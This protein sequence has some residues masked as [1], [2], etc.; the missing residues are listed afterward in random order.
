MEQIVLKKH[1][2]IELT[3]QTRAR[4]KAQVRLCEAYDLES[5]VLSSEKGDR[6][7]VLPD[8]KLANLL[9]QGELKGVGEGPHLEAASRQSWVTL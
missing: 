7:R 2:P 5:T 4:L 6:L 8:P 1:M 9:V 3:V